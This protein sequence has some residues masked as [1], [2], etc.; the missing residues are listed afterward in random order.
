MARSRW[1]TC[2]WTASTLTCPRATPTWSLR[3]LRRRRRRLNTWME[4][5]WALNGVFE[6]VFLWAE[7]L[8]T[9][10]K[11]QR[12]PLND[13]MTCPSWL[14]STFWPQLG[15]QC[16]ADWNG[17]WQCECLLCPGQ[18][19]GQE[20]TVIAVLAPT[21]RPAPRRMSPPRR[22]PPPPPMWRRTPPRMRRRWLELMSTEGRSGETNN[23]HN[24]N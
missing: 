5:R 12:R 1:S 15:M 6:L 14:Y 4:V 10:E 11:V 19:D 8:Y 7:W 20:I 17:K 23:T 3:R 21:V 22:M 18:I 24:C 13:V 16:G 2:P 9:L